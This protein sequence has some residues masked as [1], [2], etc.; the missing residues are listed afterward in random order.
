MSRQEEKS[1]TLYNGK[2]YGYEVS[3]Y[4]LK[5]GY[6]DY[7]TL[8]KIVGDMIL[9]NYMMQYMGSL[10]WELVNGDDIDEDGEYHEIYQWYIIT[11]TGARFLEEYTDEIVYYHEEM[12]LYVWGITHFGTSWDHVLTDIK[13]NISM[14]G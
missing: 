1:I 8:S 6:L 7:R 5:N 10:G 4:G 3:E 11:E 14:E 13:L 12:D 2:A 9:S